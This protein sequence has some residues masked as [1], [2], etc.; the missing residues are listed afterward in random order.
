MAKDSLSQL[1]NELISYISDFL[2]YR[3]LASFVRVSKANHDIVKRELYYGIEL[4]GSLDRARKCLMTLSDA[5]NSAAGLVRDFA[6]SFKLVHIVLQFEDEDEDDDEEV[7]D[8]D[9]G[10]DEDEDEDED[11]DADADED[12]DEKQMEVEVLAVHLITALHNM[13]NV[14]VIILECPY[15]RE[16]L[17]GLF[18]TPKKYLKVLGLNHH[19]IYRATDLDCINETPSF[20]CQVKFPLLDELVINVSVVLE[21]DDEH[22]IKTLFL[23]HAE[24][25]KFIFGKC[26]ILFPEHITFPRLLGLSGLSASRF[27]RQLSDQMPNLHIVELTELYCDTSEHTNEKLSGYFENLRGVDCNFSILQ[28]LLSSPRPLGRI[29]VGPGKDSRWKDFRT[30]IEM[31]SNCSQSLLTLEINIYVLPTDYGEVKLE[32]A[33]SSIPS[34]PHLKTFY[35]FAPISWKRYVQNPLNAL[36]IIPK[37]L[38]SKLPQ[39]EKFIFQE[40]QFKRCNSNV[41]R[42]ILALW[43]QEEIPPSLHEIIFQ[44]NPGTTTTWKRA[45]NSW[46]KYRV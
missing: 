44:S 4:S 27:R 8:E 20:N 36:A 33:W 9:D 29:T 46:E 7:E 39:L 22:L 17:T 23:N 25:L 40:D 35:M 13:S 19:D 10:G 18:S 3:D 37:A 41:Q 6:F 11:E 2:D 16:V 24:Q 30:T 32:E 15:Y 31:L 43:V 38:F 5:S 26:E 45:G 12:E 21:S 42:E 1:P 28:L 14:R 34:L